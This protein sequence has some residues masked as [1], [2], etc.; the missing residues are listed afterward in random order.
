MR[1]EFTAMPAQQAANDLR[2]SP[3]PQRHAALRAERPDL[4]DNICATHQQVVDGVVD[5][6]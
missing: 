1:R 5:T 4:D 2:L 6:V 3:W